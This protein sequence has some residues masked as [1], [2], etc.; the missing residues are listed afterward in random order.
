ML[1]VQC[2]KLETFHLDYTMD[3]SHFGFTDWMLSSKRIEKT[4]KSCC[5]DRVYKKNH[6]E[7]F[8]HRFKNSQ[9]QGIA[10]V[11]VNKRLSLTLL[12]ACWTLFLLLGCLSQPWCDQPGLT[13]AVPGRSAL[14]W[15]KVESRSTWGRREFEGERLGKGREGKL[16]SVSSRWEMNKR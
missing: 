11:S 12:P 15:G 6:Q 3:Q 2:W 4:I 16:Q 10:D 8:L 13:V 14:F 9:K 1:T 5:K 7:H